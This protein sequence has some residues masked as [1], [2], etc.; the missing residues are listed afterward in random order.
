VTITHP[1]HPLR[2]Q[3]VEI[4][5][6]HQSAEPEIVVQLPDGLHARIPASWTDYPTP[7]ERDPPADP[8]HLLDLDGLRQ[9][10]Q[11][12]DHIRR[13]GRGDA[14]PP[15]DASEDEGTYNEAP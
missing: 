5:H 2:G 15:G 9:V 8:A 6:L 1:C 14:C 11:F 13:D 4:I 3:Q 7:Q 12:I 10:V